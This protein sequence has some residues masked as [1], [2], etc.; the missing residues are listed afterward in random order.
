MIFV[1]YLTVSSIQHSL[2]C[3]DADRNLKNLGI[4]HPHT[5]EDPIAEWLTSVSVLIDFISFYISISF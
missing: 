5:V 1:L 4:V 2:T 3:P